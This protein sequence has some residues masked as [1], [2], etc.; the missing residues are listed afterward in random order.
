MVRIFANLNYFWHTSPMT[1]LLLIPLED[2]VV[3]PGMDVTLP[4]DVGDESRVLLVPRHGTDYAN[5][6]LVAEVGEHMRLPGRIHAVSLS[7]LHRG[8]AGAANTDPQGRLWV[9]VDERPDETPPPSRTRELEREYRA[10]VEEILELRGDDGRVSAFVRSITEPG[11]LADTSGYSPDL[12]FEQK[13]ELLQTDRRRRAAGAGAAPAAR[14]PGRAAGAP[15][16]PRRRRVRR[17]EA[18]ARVLPAQ[19]DGLDPQGARRRRRVGGRGVPGARSTRPACPT[20]CASR[21]SASSRRLERMGESTG[22]SSMI[23]TYLDWLIAV[24]WSKRT[25]ER[26]DPVHAR[27]VLDADHAG[28][29][30][31]KERITEYLAVRKLRADRG[32]P[33]TAAPASS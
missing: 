6:G 4:V 22:E 30:D 8:I 33:T 23:R 10:V 18:A 1:K 11:A 28:L 27:E 3:F 20:T 25:E 32:V 21:P 24:P 26:L 9:E 2:T 13:V 19:A 31:V 5:V 7:G 29:D 14:P 17:P 12:T 15:A 16:H